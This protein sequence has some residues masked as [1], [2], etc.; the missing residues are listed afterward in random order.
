MATQKKRHVGL[1][2]TLTLLFVL[3]ILP[4]GLAYALCFDT[5]TTSFVG[6]ETTDTNK[7][8]NQRVVDGFGQTKSTGKI[9][10]A[11]GENDI[12]QLLFNAQK[13]LPEQAKTYVKKFYCD[14][15]GNNYV[16]SFDA[17]V[18]LFKT[19]LRLATTL[20]QYD[21]ATGRGVAFTIN[22]VQLGR[23]PGLKGIGQSI[24]SNFVTDASLTEMFASTGL[25]MKVSLTEGKITYARTD[26]I[27]DL[28]KMIGGEGNSLMSSMLD[29][30]FNNNLT[31]LNPDNGID[32]IFDLAK[33]HTNPDYSDST[34][35]LGIDIND[36]GSKI[37][38][39]LKNGI[40]EDNP[41]SLSHVMNYLV[42]GYALATGSAQSYVSGK[43][44]SCI[45]I[46]NIDAYKGADLASDTSI[47]ETLK[48]RI[49]VA[50]IALGKIGYIDEEDLNDVLASTKAVGQ[51]MVL[52]YVDG[53]K[54]SVACVC[55]DDIYTNIFN[56]HFYL[57]LGLSVNGYETSIVFD[58]AF[59]GIKNYAMT[60]K[61]ENLYF[62]TL[63]MSEQLKSYFFDIM[64]QSLSGDDALSFKSS[65]GVFTFDIQKAID[66]ADTASRLAI[67]L[68][69]G[70][71]KQFKA[72]ASGSKLSD[73]GSIIIT[74]E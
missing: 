59:Q 63:S 39:L 31:S 27:A 62:G 23:L 1:I 67:S 44:F 72:A 45:G 52:D 13:T 22:D 20:A 70:S 43:D 15:S 49:N 47:T 7:M 73:T 68:A 18:P 32:I 56:N 35:S 10:I 46:T 9:D 14:I 3:I 6:N 2:V 4:V 36:I 50:D 5:T 64:Q 12:N 60:L 53:T 58:T 24:A 66:S 61:V 33:L 55:I 37:Q 21:D 28:K 11:I 48:Q 25:N 19:R 34:H 74:I 71:G 51:G 40:I 26:Y 42:R 57:G 16:F 8:M 17:E 30:L 54:S 29:E 69:L 65:T 41:N 38:T